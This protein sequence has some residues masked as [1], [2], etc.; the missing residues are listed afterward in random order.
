[1]R[2]RQKTGYPH[3]NT[4]E[5][6]KTMGHIDKIDNLMGFLSF[7]LICS[8]RKDCIISLVYNK[9]SSCV[10]QICVCHVLIGFTAL[11][12]IQPGLVLD[13]WKQVQT[14]PQKPVQMS[15]QH[16]WGHIC[17]IVSSSRLPSTR[18][19]WTY[20]RVDHRVSLLWGKTEIW[21][22]EKRKF[23]RDLIDTY[24]YP[25]GEGSEDSQA[26]FSGAHCQDKWQWAQTVIQEVAYRHQCPGFS[27]D[28]TGFL[29]S[30]WY[31]A[32]FWLWEKIKCYSIL[33]F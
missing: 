31:D 32:L 21:N 12:W 3:Y 16:W 22:W 1:M 27:W 13:R 7:R 23:D 11:S 28:R 2:S 10:V 25:K 20:W 33:M 9:D 17:S 30:A 19:M 26:L 24:K 18:E 4:P 29:R 15:T 6:I 14:S 8:L 5:L